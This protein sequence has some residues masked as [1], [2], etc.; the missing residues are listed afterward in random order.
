MKKSLLFIIAL[1]FT[2]SA[3]S[4]NVIQLFN[5]ANDFFKLLQEEK[6]TDAHAFFD[7]TLKTKLTEENLK[8]LWT[9]I[10][11][12]Y[13]KA[14]SFDAIQ[15]KAQGEFFAVTVEGKFAN[16]NQNFILGF[17]KMQKIVGIFLAPSKKVTTY[18]KPPYVDTA[19]YVEKSVYIGPAGKQVAAVI[20]TPK[21]IKN[22]PM[23]VLVHG[24]GPADMDETVGANKP[25]KDLAGGLASKGI[26]SVR[27]V[28]RTLIYPNEFAGPF[29]VKEEVLDDASAAIAVART[30]A[31]A[32]PKN[33]FVFGHSLGGML[34][35]KMATLSPDLAGIILAAAPARK[36]TDVIVDQN[37][38]MFDQANDTTAAFKKQL[39]DA[40]IEIDKSRISQLGTTVKPDSI[41]LGLPAKYWADLNSYNQVATAK[42]LSK[43]RIYVLQGGNDFQVSKTDFDL[44]NEALGKKKNVTLKFYPDL[45]HL[46]SPQSG[47]G[48]MAQYQAAA[49]VSDVLINDLVLWIKAK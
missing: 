17:N 46:L 28:K 19:L 4:Q 49:S 32:D 26:G 47:K 3:F 39:A 27:Y 20:T 42:G 41:I 45:N 30:A 35:P 40:M 9:D 36:L 14:E 33:I 24:S 11:A 18:L 37:Q 15:S 38:Y 8:K 44:W 10:G 31:G 48:T 6:F 23:V 21:N 12:K 34:A 16:G 43:P 29:T 13:G 5:G 25:F 22:F 7:D 2:T 1:L